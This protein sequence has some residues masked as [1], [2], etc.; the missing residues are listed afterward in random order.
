MS[1]WAA[2]D[3][4]PLL[5]KYRELLQ[6][7][8]ALVQRVNARNMERMPSWRLAILALEMSASGFAL[9]HGE[10]M[11]LANAR[12]HELGRTQVLGWRRLPPEAPGSPAL[13]TLREAA[14]LEA[15]AV[16]ARA[17]AGPRVTRYQREGGLQTLELR[18]E[19]VGLP[20]ELLVLVIA[21]DITEQ[22]RAEEELKRTR[23]ALAEREHLRTLGEMAS[24]IVHDLG[25]TLGAARIRLE[26]L[27]ADPEY[28]ARH[29]DPLEALMR[30]FTDASTRIHR[31]QDFARH[32]PEHPGEQ[33][34][35]GDVIREA[36]E[37]LRG[38]L[39]PR[40]ARKGP[41]LRIDVS[42]PSLP[43]IHGSAADLRYVFLNLFLNARDAM[44]QGGTVRVRGFHEGKQVII[45]VE[46]EGTGIP[47]THLGSIFRPFFTTKGDR[48]TG[49]GLSMA[50]GV[51]SRVGGTITAANRPEGG[52]LFTLTFPVPRA[53]APTR[54]PARKRAPQRRARRAR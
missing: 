52:A 14:R 31:L 20:Q 21:H 11:Q 49:L 53:P 8:S 42:V 43:T 50:H 40:A 18:T 22:V 37:L 41:G 30:I 2:A 39:E 19:Q 46:D 47:E 44:P 25:S 36:R 23:E 29:Q 6:K 5:R 10:V 1:S 24:G 32:R 45:T 9:L 33:V 34:Q 27:Q 48:G 51:V 13:V 15:R 35:L 26:L 4:K 3:L 28:A 54:R 16:L 17:G 38:D 12:W 7:H